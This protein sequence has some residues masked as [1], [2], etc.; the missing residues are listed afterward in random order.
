M[1]YIPGVTLKQLILDREKKKTKFSDND[2]ALILKSI[3]EG[4]QYL[5]KLN[6]IHRDL[7]PGMYCK[8]YLRKH[9]SF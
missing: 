4:I 1:E 6:I 2:T 3:L 5:H 7:K 8:N 9:F